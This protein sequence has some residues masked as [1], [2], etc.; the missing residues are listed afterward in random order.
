MFPRDR[1]NPLQY[2]LIR[3]I[4]TI[5]LSGKPGQGGTVCD[6]PKKMGFLNNFNVVM[7]VNKYY[8]NLQAYTHIMSI[9]VKIM[10]KK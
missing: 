3:S 6:N 9:Q 10:S 1:V 7:F 8:L 2:R 5:Y 4:D